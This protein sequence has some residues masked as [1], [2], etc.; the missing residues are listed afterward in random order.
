MLSV[1]SLLGVNF[2]L[3]DLAKDRTS[4]FLLLEQIDAKS[5][6]HRGGYGSMSTLYRKCKFGHHITI[7]TGNSV[8]VMYGPDF[9]ALNGGEL[10]L[11]F[12]LFDF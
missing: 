12:I 2:A 4:A 7:S 3:S 1:K 8:T 10:S 9:L 11:F 6:D 5:F